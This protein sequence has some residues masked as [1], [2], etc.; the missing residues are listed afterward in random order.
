MRNDGMQKM[1]LL[2]PEC[3]DLEEVGLGSM[4]LEK[5]SA[6]TGL[7]ELSDEMFCCRIQGESNLAPR[8]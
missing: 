6:V 2:L 7:K 1:Q 4:L 3:R 8:M 5:E